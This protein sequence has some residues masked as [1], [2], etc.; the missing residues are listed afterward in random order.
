MCLSQTE[1]K[2]LV[3][4]NFHSFKK[5]DS[6]SFIIA[7]SGFPNVATLIT[8]QPLTLSTPTL[9]RSNVF[10]VV[11]VFVRSTREMGWA[12]GWKRLGGDSQKCLKFILRSSYDRLM[13]ILWSSYD[14]LMIILWSSYDH[15]MSILW[16][17]YNHLTIILQLSYNHLTIISQS[18]YNHLIIILQSSYNDA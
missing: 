4:K 12:W 15:L 2:F 3:Q 8:S 5:K 9:R 17:S 11:S 16:S 6:V 13:I 18:S 14:R 10:F 1:I 7:S